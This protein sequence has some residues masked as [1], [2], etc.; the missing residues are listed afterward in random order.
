VS[1]REKC[2]YYEVGILTELKT[3]DGSIDWARY[4]GNVN[5]K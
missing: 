1:R 2:R 3:K 5:R 4:E